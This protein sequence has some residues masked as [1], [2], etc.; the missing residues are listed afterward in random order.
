MNVSRAQ[1]LQRWMIDQRRGSQMPVVAPPAM[2]G[3]ADDEFEDDPDSDSDSD[4]NS[5]S[6]SDMTVRQDDYNRSS[7]TRSIF[8]DF[9]DEMDDI[10]EGDGD[11]ETDEL[12]DLQDS[13][14][15]ENDEND[16]LQEF[17]WAAE[18]E[19]FVELYAYHI[20]SKEDLTVDFAGRLHG[21]FTLP[22]E[23]EPRDF[24]ILGYMF[25][26]KELAW[27]C[28]EDVEGDAVI[29]ICL[30]SFTIKPEAEGEHDTCSGFGANMHS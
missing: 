7:N 11:D 6:D 20:W 14:D 9:D 16:G 10:W 27:V 4:S 15:S 25:W 28:L 2:E 29:G 3:M 26:R 1:H 21:R 5:D 12:G 30:H 23:R 8:E 13:D 18:P 17:D 22:D 19:E 24:N